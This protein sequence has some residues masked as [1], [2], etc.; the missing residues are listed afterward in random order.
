MDETHIATPA[1]TGPVP[2]A[3]GGWRRDLGCLL[4][5]LLLASALRVWQMVHTEVTSRDSIMFIEIAWRLEHGDW[6]DVITH[7]S[8]QHPGYPV[9][10]LAVS[11]PV[12]QFFHG[13]LATAMQ[14]SAQL[15]SSLAGVLLV[16]P[17]FF[18]GREL[19]DRRVAFWAT[20]LFQ[21]LPTSGRVLGDGLSE[22]L[23][24]LWAATALLFAV[25]GLRTLSPWSFAAAGLATGLAYLARPEGLVIALCAGLVLVAMQGV[26]RWR[27]PHAAV[28]KCGGALTAATLAVALPFICLIHGL[29]VKPSGKYFE[30][31]GQ[32]L[33]RMPWLRAENA[34]PHPE[35]VRQAGMATN[36][37]PWAVWWVGPASADRHG[38]GLRALGTV[39]L[40]SFC[41]AF[42]VP[43]LLGLWRFRDRFRLVPG[44]WVLLLTSLLI[45][46]ALYRLAVLMGYLS[47]RHT[48][49]ILLC[50]SYWTAAGLLV[51]A[52]GLQRFL[53]RYVPATAKWG[54]RGMV[55]GFVVLALTAAP[56]ARTL[57]P[58]HADRAGFR[59]AGYWLAAE[60]LPGDH[61]FDPY[62]W[63][64]YYAG[65]YFL[66]DTGSLPA[67]EPSRWYVILEKAENPHPHLMEVR[68]AELYAKAGR[69]VKSWEVPR[70][71][72][73]AEV[74]VFL[75]E[76]PSGKSRPPVSP[77]AG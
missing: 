3:S 33:E 21:C 45:S 30:H 5:L 58:L 6:R 49:L 68:I 51:V 36:S 72:R 50:A 31:P 57:Q 16:V 10:V 26:A 25:R 29:T 65:R 62:S 9:A 44:S 24:L 55:A 61:I 37:L 22:S 71:K 17:M 28:L 60:T 46:L 15:A 18:L 53:V 1:P 69:M 73:K 43:A 2:P 34:G 70:G 56:L 32:K 54:G 52:S 77:P 12:R 23:F 19:F 8:R 74:Q 39:L 59:A 48:L 47:D 4:L 13:D 20:A 75:I 76:V 27:R 41:Y 64:N 38:W 7:H 11:R 14:L 42:W 63:S 35:A 66:D 40:K 67:H